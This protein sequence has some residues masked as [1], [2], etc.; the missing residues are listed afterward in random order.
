MYR[1]KI[2]A[3]ARSI[4]INFWLLYVYLLRHYNIIGNITIL[5][6]DFFFEKISM[7]LVGYRLI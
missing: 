2:I 6:N 3:R 7:A 5:N 1:L 4:T